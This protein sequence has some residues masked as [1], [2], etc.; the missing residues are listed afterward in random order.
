MASKWEEKKAKLEA[1]L[2]V[3]EQD[4]QRIT[5]KAK[6]TLAEIAECDR[7]I[8]EATAKETTPA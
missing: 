8:A 4:A 5:H 7:L 1:R 3:L 2:K 6:Q